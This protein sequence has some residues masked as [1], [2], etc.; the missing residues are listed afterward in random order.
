MPNSLSE[1]LIQRQCGRECPLDRCSRIVRA[2]KIRI[3]LPTI[4]RLS[5][6]SEVLTVVFNPTRKASTIPPRQ[7]YR[8]GAT[9]AAISVVDSL[10]GVLERF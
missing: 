7:T 6:V 4:P 9:E 3:F 5:R 1:V 2:R 10:A 8:F